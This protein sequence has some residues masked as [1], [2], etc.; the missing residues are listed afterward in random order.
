MCRRKIC[1]VAI[2]FMSATPCF[3]QDAGLEAVRIPLETIWALDMP[4]ARDIHGI[5]LGDFDGRSRPGW[6]F[7]EFRKERAGGIEE[8]RKS[9]AIKAPSEDA[10]PGFIVPSAADA[11]AL[12]YASSRVAS[13]MRYEKQGLGAYSFQ[14]GNEVT[15]VFFT[16]PSSYYVQLVNVERRGGS[17]KVQYRVVPHFTAESTVHFA[18]IPLGKLPAGEYFVEFEQ[19]PMERKFQE[20]GFIRY[21]STKERRLVCR[22][23]SFT[24]WDPPLAELEAPAEG[25]TLVP[26][27][28]IWGYRMPG[29][30][31]VRELDG[32]LGK[33]Q[34]L[35]EAPSNRIVRWLMGR[36]PRE[37]PPGLGPRTQLRADRGFVVIGEGAKSLQAA[38]D[39]LIR[40]RQDREGVGAGS[41][42][43]L[44][45][46]AHPAP[47][48]VHIQGVEWVNDEIA[49]KYRIVPHET[50]E[51]TAHFA[52][53]PLGTPKEGEYRVRMIQLPT[54]K[55]VLG[56]REIDPAVVRRTV[57]GDFT[58]F[59]RGGQ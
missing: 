37:L 45:F 31:D 22:S 32:E 36:A 11:N 40:P 26:L 12:R 6:G 8:F 42:V 2:V 43:T 58:F 21:D 7:E 52:L 48:Y 10:M 16:H 25:A 14:S 49:V 29:T 50:M 57:C 47:G 53:I 5:D 59:V 27:D 28:Q 20:A 33:D 55:D 39:R 41:K 38:W 17:I 3:A 46:F 1:A 4:G 13:A 30:R 24:V 15:L 56:G 19:A 23:F 35:S 44:V 18:L 54:P 34:P 51:S 9:L